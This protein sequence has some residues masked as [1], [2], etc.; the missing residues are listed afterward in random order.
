[1]CG[2]AGF[3]ETGGR[4]EAAASR[5]IAT[6]MAARLTARGPDAAG[7]WAADDGAVAFGHRRLSIIDISPAGAQPMRSA[8]GRWV[9]AYNGEIYNADEMRAQLGERSSPFRG[10]ADTEV[11][12]E[13]IDAVGVEAAAQ[14]ANGIFAFAAWDRETRKLWLVRDRLGVKP[15]YW[16]RAGGAWLFASQPKAFF[17]HP[18]F[19]PAIDADGLTAYLRYGYVPAPLS[20]YRGIEK[21]PGGWLAEIDARGN[22]NARC[23]WDLR[24]IAAEGQAAPEPHDANALAAL[25]DDAVGRQMVSDVP[26]GAFLSGGI[27]SSA[28]VAAMQARGGARVK[29]FAVGFDESG[30]D[31]TAHARAVSKHLGTEHTE[32][33]LKPSDVP[34]LF[35]AALEGLDEPVTDVSLLPMFAVSRLARDHVTVALSGDGG[36]ELFAGYQHYDLGRRAWDVARRLPGPLGSGTRATV[37][38]LLPV[39]QALPLGGTYSA[40]RIAKVAE[41]LPAG[42]PMTVYRRLVSVWPKPDRISDA[43][44]GADAT[45]AA[46]AP[47]SG[48]GPLQ[49]FRCFDMLAYLPESI[50]AKVDRASMATSLEARVPLLDHRIVERAWRT[51]P[52]DL[53][54]DG[55]TK[56]PLREVLYRRVPRELIERPKMGFGVPM[57]DWLRGPLRAWAERDLAQVA[58]G[59]LVRSG[60]VARRW[61]EHLSGRR[62]WQLSLWGIVVLAHWQRRWLGG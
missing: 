10:H 27:D 54:R 56:W 55:L 39:L 8:S 51:D 7:D 11:L 18:A 30:F 26:L 32:L 41:L 3:L 38:A 37:A 57:G 29:T 62:N 59:G 9:I 40:D 16:G 13:T 33:R 61:R 6:Q 17:A 19:S 45:L 5:A 47:P 12:L 48:F 60:P 49:A 44:T 28:V 36:D 52:R 43:A 20:I 42:D 22:V 23:W 46:T 2:I 50:L 15:L 34:E 31:E 53:V 21:L 35:D 14:R 4:T 24:A 1:M 25:I 58:A